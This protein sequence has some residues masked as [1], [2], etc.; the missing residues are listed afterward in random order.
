M[1]DD[2]SVDLQRLQ[3]NTFITCILFTQLVKR[4][5]KQCWQTNLQISTKQTITSNHRIFLKLLKFVLNV[6]EIFATER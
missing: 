4:K 5:S 2:I 6:H 1:M 3:Y